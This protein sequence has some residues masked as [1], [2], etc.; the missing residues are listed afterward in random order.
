MTVRYQ[1]CWKPLA[2]KQSEAGLSTLLIDCF[3]KLPNHQWNALYPFD[4][5]LS[6]DQLPLKAPARLSGYSS[7]RRN[8]GG[9]SQPLFILNVFFLQIDISAD[10]KYQKMLSN[11]GIAKQSYSR[12]LCSFFKVEYSS[13]SSLLIPS[14]ESM[15]GIELGGTCLL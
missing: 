4:L 2:I 3:H 11:T 14:K 7:G 9:Y 1:C 13:L 10:G 15:F 12:C 8:F 5:L 6:S